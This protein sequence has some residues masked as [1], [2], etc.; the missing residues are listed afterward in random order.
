MRNIKIELQYDGSRYDGWQKQGNTDQTIQGKIE[1]ILEKMTGTAVEVHGAGRTDAGVHALAQTANFKVPDT[2]SV[3]SV[4]E[5]MNQYLPEDIAVIGAEEK[6]SR[7]HSRLNAVTKRT[8]IPLK[9]TKR[10]AFLKENTF[11]ASADG[12]ISGR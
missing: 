11:M 4:K 3:Q 8:A 7:F 12:W 6:D 9:R 2:F 1:G 10:R 5:Y